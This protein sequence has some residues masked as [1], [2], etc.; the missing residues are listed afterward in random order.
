MPSSEHTPG[1]WF[2]LD[3]LIHLEREGLDML[4][5]VARTEV[6][7]GVISGEE[8]IANARV[9]AAAPELL[10]AAR[11]EERAERH[12]RACSGCEDLTHPCNVYLNLRRDAEIVRQAAITKAEGRP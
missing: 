4:I 1:P 12:F 10:E 3:R 5:R 11:L 2:A 8:A 6:R 7:R 9:I